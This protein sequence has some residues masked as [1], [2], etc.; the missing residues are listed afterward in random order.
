MIRFNLNQLK[1]F[2]LAAKHKNFTVAAQL[3]N[4]TQPAVSLQIKSLE[5]FYNIR[6][7]SRIGKQ[8]VLTDAG[9]ILYEHADGI[10]RLTSRM[11]Q[12]LNDLKN[13]RY[14]ILRMGT[15]Q[16]FAHYFMPDLIARYRELFPDIRIV[17]FEGSS[18]DNL[19]AVVEG[20]NELGIV[21]RIPYDRKIGYFPLMEEPL[22]LVASPD[23]PAI[24]KM[25][26]GISVVDLQGLPV[27]FREKGSSIRHV[28]S[29]FCEKHQVS[30]KVKIE[31][32]SLAFIRDLVVHGHG[33][34]FF[35]KTA[36]IDEVNEGKLVVLPIKEGTP[37]LVIDV[38]SRKGV[39]FSYA[40][41]A[42]LNLLGVG[43]KELESSRP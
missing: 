5:N 30:P 12:T 34:S 14:G 33:L 31:S 1:I 38:V 6:L 41:R 32:G 24:Q 43:D 8:L 23:Y 40:A 26:G 15:T 13:L 22:W 25:T 29:T 17:L 3:L 27:I 36:V 21:G 4:I 9:Q 37:H 2:Y 16:T 20:K 19:Q 7:F 18:V 10:F 35:I 39:H 11:V 42:F 28:V